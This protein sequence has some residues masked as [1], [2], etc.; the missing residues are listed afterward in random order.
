MGEIVGVET[1]E[2][3]TGD[4]M[5]GLAGSEMTAGLAG[6][7]AGADFAAGIIV[8]ISDAERTIGLRASC[9][10]TG[11]ETD[12]WDLIPA[13]ALGSGLNRGA[14]VLDEIGNLKDFDPSEGAAGG[15]DGGDIGGEALTDFGGAGEEMTGL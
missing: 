4:L 10:D 12:S 7:M 5:A 15:V 6:G 14:E 9:A 13:D 2:R 8:G 11:L 3:T 1:E